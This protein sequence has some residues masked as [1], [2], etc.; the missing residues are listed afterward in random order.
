[1][2]TC[3]VV[4][5]GV[6]TDW[7]QARLCHRSMSKTQ[8][9]Q[10]PSG[11]TLDR[12]SAAAA[13]PVQSTTR[14]P[15][16][17]RQSARRQRLWLRCCWGPQTLWESGK[18]RPNTARQCILLRRRVKCRT[19]STSW[20]DDFHVSCF[21]HPYLLCGKFAAVGPLI[22]AFRCAGC[23]LPPCHA[24]YRDYYRLWP[25]V[26]NY[27]WYDHV[28]R[29]PSGGK[30]ASCEIFFLHRISRSSWRFRVIS[31]NIGT[32]F[33]QA[34]INAFEAARLWQIIWLMRQAVGP[35]S[36]HGIDQLGARN[37]QFSNMIRWRQPVINYDTKS[38]QLRDTF[39]SWK[40]WWQLHWL[41]T[42]TSRF[43]LDCIHS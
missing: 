19:S 11:A 24:D 2:C 12:S 38:R 14:V 42:R 10:S 15:G 34:D 27:C 13:G 32:L 5:Y 23:L 36:A 3:C 18:L 28:T 29:R 30:V 22:D 17:H 25:L 35:Q 39:Y 7:L 8:C 6:E 16:G 4:K 43:G 41:P 33:A 9:R 31:L 20:C 26:I 1:M 40:W 21:A 37:Q